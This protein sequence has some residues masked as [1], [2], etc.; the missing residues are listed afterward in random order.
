[1]IRRSPTVEETKQTNKCFSKVPKSCQ[2]FL[3]AIFLSILL[4]S[5]KTSHV[6]RLEMKR[7]FENKYCRA[8]KVK[9]TKSLKVFTISSHLQIYEQNCYTVPNKSYHF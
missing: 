8:D 7:Q 1:M 9:V 4:G 5:I 2:E 3:V 6:I